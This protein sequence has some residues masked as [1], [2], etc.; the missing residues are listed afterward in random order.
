M[1][2]EIAIAN[3]KASN[4]KERTVVAS[5]REALEIY[6]DSLAVW[7]IMSFPTRGNAEDYARVKCVNAQ[8]ELEY[9]YN[10]DALQRIWAEAQKQ[11]QK[12]DALYL[13]GGW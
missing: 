7:T 8:Y 13:K 6:R 10:N 1:A 3:D 9:S 5:Y 2:T 4:V 11:M 12:A